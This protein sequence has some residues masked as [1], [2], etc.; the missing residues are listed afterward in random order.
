MGEGNLAYEG[1]WHQR[2]NPLSQATFHERGASSSCGLCT[3]GIRVCSSDGF[4]CTDS[5]GPSYQSQDCPPKPTVL[6]ICRGHDMVDHPST[7]GA[8]QLPCHSR[9]FQ[10]CCSSNYKS[11]DSCGAG[12]ARKQ[13]SYNQ[14]NFQSPPL[15]PHSHR[16]EGI[17][18]RCHYPR[19]PA[20]T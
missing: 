10:S 11:R 15:A 3:I 1:I 18:S 4:R 19:Q 14:G 20:P 5:T 6:D 13:S 7:C 12:T 2:G 17:R 8:M 16:K 9:R